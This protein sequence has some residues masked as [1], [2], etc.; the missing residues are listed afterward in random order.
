MLLSLHFLFCFS[1]STE[2]LCTKKSTPKQHGVKLGTGKNSEGPKNARTFSQVDG[3]DGDVVLAPF[4]EGWDEFSLSSSMLTSN[5]EGEE[6]VPTDA[7]AHQDKKERANTLLFVCFFS[8]CKRYSY[9]TGL[10]SCQRAILG[11]GRV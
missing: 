11:K 5:D 4:P 6:G 9:A 10:T 8:F 1:V 7:A 2:D 3:N